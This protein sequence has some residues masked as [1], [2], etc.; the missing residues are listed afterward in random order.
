MKNKKIMKLMKK[1]N[2]FT[3][4]G[5]VKCNCGRTVKLDNITYIHPVNLNWFDWWM[6]ELN[7]NN[8]TSLYIKKWYGY[9]GHVPILHQIVYYLHKWFA[10]KAYLILIECKYCTPNEDN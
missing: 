1:Q 2:K 6:Y 9:A 4:K 3:K 8:S 10:K 5:L 7:D